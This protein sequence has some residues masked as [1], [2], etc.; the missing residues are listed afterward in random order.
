MAVG[1]GAFPCPPPPPSPH[2]SP[3][4]GGILPG[5][6]PRG[7]VHISRLKHSSA[8]QRSGDK[9]P[10][11]IPPAGS[12]PR[13]CHSHLHNCLCLSHSSSSFSCPPEVLMSLPPGSFCC[14]ALL[15]QWS[16]CI[17]SA[18]PS[19][20]IITLHSEALPPLKEG[21]LCRQVPCL[22]EL[23]VLSPWHRARFRRPRLVNVC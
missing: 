20:I 12:H 16:P 7:A 19:S 17:S 8:F 1:K 10:T 23:C 4:S 9:D 14:L 5:S 21:A 22:S 3:G 18:S 13:H 15:A 11:S 6:C 2:R